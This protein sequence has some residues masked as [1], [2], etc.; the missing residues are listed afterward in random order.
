MVACDSV[1]D[2]HAR[3]GIDRI[4]APL[5]L[6]LARIG[7]TPSHVTLLGLAITITGGVFIGVGWLALGAGVGGFGALLDAVDGPL[8]RLTGKE[9]KRGALL[10][11]VGDRLGE[12]A[13]WLGL[14]WSVAGDRQRVI[15]CMAAL[16][17]AM[18]IPYVRSK[19]EGWGAEGGG[20]VMGRAERLIFMLL[21]VGLEGLGLPLILFMLWAITVLN[22]ITFGLRAVRTWSQLKA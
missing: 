20:G 11:T 18:L 6:R 19:A 7:I 22:T 4:V 16:G 10:D 8:A 21:M 5:G 13:L 1:L 2:I 14:A 3:K 17:T 15:L 12:L 9:T